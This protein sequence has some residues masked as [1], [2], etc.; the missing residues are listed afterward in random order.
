MNTTSVPS[1]QSA[2]SAR[3]KGT[4]HLLKVT[5]GVA[6]VLATLFTAWTPAEVDRQSEAGQGFNFN[7]FAAAQ[8]QEEDKPTPTPRSRPLI[9]IVA[10]HWGSDAGTVCADGLTEAEVNLRIASLVQKYLTD[11]E[12]DV[13]LLQEFDSRLRGYSATALVSIHADSCDYVNDQATGFKVAAALANSYPERGTRLT[14]CLRNRYTLASSLPLHTTSVTP[15]MTSYHAFDEID[16][17]TTAAIIETG[18]MNLDRQFLTEHPDLAAR[19]IA[20]GILCFIN[21]ESI[22]PI[23]PQPVP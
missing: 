14:A 21:N 1:P 3:P 22:T 2:A 9:G 10:G 20:D 4:F 23:T 17:G 8:P 5:F 16:D 13:D 18:F 11:S 6:L 12:L 19:G 7:P 15:D